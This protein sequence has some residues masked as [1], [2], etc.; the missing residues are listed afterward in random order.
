MNRGKN[1]PLPRLFEYRDDQMFHFARLHL[2]VGY[3]TS[4][5]CEG[6][7]L[8]LTGVV[9]KS[10]YQLRGTVLFRGKIA[11]YEDFAQIRI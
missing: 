4:I 11:N 3:I 1:I 5:W 9:R 8:R 7:K 2:W 6:K 10:L